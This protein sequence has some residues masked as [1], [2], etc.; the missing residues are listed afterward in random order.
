MMGERFGQDFS[1]VRVHTDAQAAAS[2][3]ALGARAYTHGSHLVFSAARYSP[4]TG[5]GKRLLTHELA[6]VVQ[7]REARSHLGSSHESL[8]SRSG[9][10]AEFAAERAAKLARSGATAASVRR[11][12]RA[13]RPTAAIQCDVEDPARYRSVHSRLFSRSVGGLLP[14]Q[15]PQ[16]GVEGTAALLT[17]QAKA[18][19]QA[20]MAATT[21]PSEAAIPTRTTEA[22]LDADAVSVSA[23]VRNRFPQI[24]TTVSESQVR[25]AVSVMTPAITTTREYLQQYTS[26]R[27]PEWSDR[28][29]YDIGETDTRYTAVLDAIIDDTDVGSY[30]RRRAQL[31]AGFQR[32]E[33]TSRGIFVHRG[34]Q[35]GIER[36]AVLVHEFTHFF[37]HRSYR[38]WVATTDAERFYN[39]GFTEYLARQAMTTAER[40]GRSS[41]DQRVGA[42]RNQVAQ[43][44]PD[45][46]IARAYFGGEIWRIETRSTIARREAGTQLGL[47][48]T[49]TRR[50]QIET[51]RTGPGINQTVY[52]G[53]HY[54]FMNLGFDRAAPK[55]EHVEFFRRFKSSYLDPDPVR[56]VRFVGHA[57][58]SGTLEYNRRLSL[59]RSQAF[60]RMA[61]DEG[62]PD[63][64]LVDAVSPPHHGETRPTAEE[65][66]PATRAFNRRVEMTVQPTTAGEAS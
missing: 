26:N 24:S 19:A 22:S 49:G 32:G 46:D 11:A 20:E 55:P 13:A 58:G 6:H 12:A 2:A 30:V 45:D 60:Y 52:L 4:E 29:N 42:I 5:D 18:S 66:D 65:E 33:G 21:L 59:R 63:T 56:S 54:R 37:S 17:R 8:L 25:Q 41:Y 57:S 36:K 51:T 40:S 23:R 43:Y 35:A 61:R 62:L 39:E 7:Q 14:W 34:A 3:K 1:D 53:R 15:S 47:R 9:D 10:A 28:E 38:D 16:P 48:E 64:R 50:E 31:V 44:V 27:M